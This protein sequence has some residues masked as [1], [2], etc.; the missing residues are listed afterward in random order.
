M[1][2]QD[3]Y[4]ATAIKPT[5]KKAKA[6]AAPAGDPYAATA[7]QAAAP[8]VSA[9]FPSSAPLPSQ[10]GFLASAAA[11][12]VG[13]AQGAWHAV[14]DE[15]RGMVE[16]AASWLP[17]ALQIKRAV[18]DPAIDQGKQAASEFS[19]ANAATPWY[20]MHPSPTAVSHRELALGH[21]L[22]AAIP[23]LGPWA[24][25]VG[26]KEGEQLGTGNYKGAA[27]TAVGNAALALAPKAAGKALAVAPE[28][29]QSIVR[30]LAG[31]G[32]GV[33]SNL[34]HAVTEDNRQIGLRNADRVA[35][36]QQ[37]WQEKQTKALADHQ[38]ELLRLRQKYAQDVRTASEKAR[39]GTDADRA[40][41][42][43]KQLAVK[44]AY[45]QSVRDARTK[46]Y[47][48]SK[49]A[50]QANVEAKRKYNQ[51]IGKTAQQNRETTVAER[52]KADQ[53]GKLQVGGS[54]L[55]YG[56]RQLDKALSDKAGV[57]FDGV[58]ELV[59][60]SKQ[61]PLPG[62]EL[63]T[64]A[65]AALAK[66]T[67]SSELPKPFR[68]ILGKYPESDPEFID[69]PTKGV[70]NLG[71]VGKD[72]PYYSVLKNQLGLGGKEAPPVTFAD[73]QG[74]YS[75][76]G[77][78]LSKG[79][80]S[81]DVYA[82]TKEL[83]NAVGDMMQK[84][85]KDAGPEA[86]KMFWDSRKFYSGYMD[87]FHE[88]TGPS[89]SGSPVAQALLAKDPLVAVD[90]FAGDSGDRGVAVLR[91]YSDSLANLAQ[92]VRQRAQTKVTVPARK[93][94]ADLPTPKTK[95]LPAGSN[96]LLPPIQEPAPVPRASNLPLPPVLPE[97]EP[98]PYRAPKLTPTKT[99]SAEDLQ[100]AN[101]AA[102]HARGQ[103]LASR[104]VGWAAIWPAFRML[105]ELTRT[106]ETSLRPLAV[107]PVAG[108][109]GMTVEALLAHPGVMDFL[110]RASKQQLARIPPD[111]QGQMPQIVAAAKVRGVPISPILAAYAATIQRNQG[112]RRPA[113]P[114][115]PSSQPAQMQ[116][117]PQ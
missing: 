32:P 82:A 49:A 35:D 76:T 90:K 1:A 37:K 27:G 53:A 20:S 67:G 28:A 71:R 84:M 91:R 107:V 117:A 55:I 114:P 30:R 79:T 63:G 98:V 106:G 40:Q 66:V 12:F 81:G 25:S 51:E 34:V 77:A 61:P 36:A 56:L 2:D 11:P 23:M 10:E 68:D 15:P 33:A 50:E 9:T 7:V 17:G 88:P 58:R 64:A 47:A 87:T 115:A 101:A 86:N 5:A 110:T 13:A 85:A 22:A 96:L 41:H 45:D 69:D 54:Q 94:V 65:R 80:L 95:P 112:G 31:S 100:R 26:E 19:Q 46:F 3:P 75:E 78:E 52:A 102:I 70:N 113:Q 29:A 38:A 72:S 92:D 103:G 73:L 89:G 4:A 62:T 39:T 44:Q 24:A 57:M 14:T 8:V 111:L 83:H 18:V 48:D 109:A 42:Q 104:L 116:G 93:S 60:K 59:A 6:A 105:S 74:Y 21:G 43:S 108:A 16:K 97:P 99:I